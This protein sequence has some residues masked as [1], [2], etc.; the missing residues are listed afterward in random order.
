MNENARHLNFA[1][2]NPIEEYTEV[3]PS[4]IEGFGLFAKKLIPKDT[5]WYHARQHDVLIITKDQ[6]QT[7]TESYKPPLNHTP[8]LLHQ[9]NRCLLTYAFYNKQCDVLVFCLD[10]ARYVN[11]SVNANSAGDTE[12]LFSR[13]LRDIQPGEEIT[14]DYSGY[15]K[16]SWVGQIKPTPDRR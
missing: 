5:V 6:Y 16:T 3:R 1:T 10:N 2:Y 8:R 9:F 7:F 15:S 12:Q 14:E 13:A 11:H 4:H